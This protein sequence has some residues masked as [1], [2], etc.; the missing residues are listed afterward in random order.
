MVG[1]FVGHPI[2]E[3][4]RPRGAELPE[5]ESEGDAVGAHPRH[6]AL[7][8]GSRR[9]EVERL[10]PLYLETVRLM[11]GQRPGLV[12]H[13]LES[14][15]L[16]GAF[17]DTLLVDATP[18][19]RRSR[20]SCA[21]FLGGMHAALVA[22]GTATL[23]TAVADVPM[24]VVYRT[25]R[26]NYFLARRLITLDD[27]ALVNLVAGCRV[28]PEF[29]QDDAEAHALAT[30]LLALVDE[31]ESRQAQRRAFSKIRVDLGGPGCGRRVAELAIALLEVE[32]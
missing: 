16:P 15:T 7:M 19:L 18:G 20:V 24:L 32:R 29:V 6:I 4:T 10:L 14:P 25:G 12:F 26:L 2:M 23:E 17:Y 8:P 5:A 1:E 13:L 21:D 30:G 28:V 11:E 22:S 31:G 27:I 9:Q 3:T